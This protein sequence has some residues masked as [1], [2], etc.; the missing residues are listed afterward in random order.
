[1]RVPLAPAGPGYLRASLPGDLLDNAAVE[2]FAEGSTAE[3]SPVPLYATGARPTRVAVDDPDPIT[4]VTKEDRS[5]IRLAYEYVGFN[6]LRGNDRY[7]IGEG[8]FLYRFGGTLY[9]LR[10]GAAA[11]DGVG[12]PHAGLDDG[13]VQPRTVGFNYGYSELELK[14]APNVAT[15]FK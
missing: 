15:L 5:E 1:L 12:G 13:T 10:M 4:S 14:L 3:R 9:S 6:G 8:S 2:Y 7:W 11:Y